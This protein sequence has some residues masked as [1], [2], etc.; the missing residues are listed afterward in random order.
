LNGLNDGSTYSYK[1]TTT[2]ND[3]NEYDSRIVNNFST[4]AQPRIS[5]LRFQPVDG[6]PTS[7]QKITWTT[8][9]PT[10][11]LITYGLDG[12]NGRDLYTAKMTTDHQMIVSDLQDNS[13]Y[14]MIAQGHDIDG[15]LAVS[16]RQLFRTALDTRPPEI[17]TI[18]E[19]TS[20]KGNGTTA[21]GQIIVSWKT[22]EPSTSQVAYSTGSAT[23][24]YNNRT[25]EDTRLTMDHVV[26]I[27]NLS[28]S[29]VYHLQPVSYDHARNRGSGED[30]SA[31]I[32]RPSDSVL[33]IILNSLH[34]VFGL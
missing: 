26:I 20:V 23:N 5:S 12:T 18:Q 16:D 10:D 3:G 11:T 17:S 19:E 13:T 21:Q 27:S 33:D 30:Q 15:N 8:N 14:F 2:D 32:G 34:K 4:P 6:V 29:T 9:V 7:T 31:I 24:G 1:L 25:A 22:D 28:V